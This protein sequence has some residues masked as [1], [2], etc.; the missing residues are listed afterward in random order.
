MMKNIAHFLLF[1]FSVNLFAASA[2]AKTDTFSTSDEFQNAQKGTEYISGSYPGAVLMPV[3]LMGAVGKAGVHHVPTKVDLL[4]FLSFAGGPN[5]DA[6]IKE[7]TLRR[8]AHGQE[9]VFD[10]NLNKIM[11]GP[12]K[13]IPIMEPNDIVYIPK[14]EEWVSSN[15]LKWITVLSLFTASVVSA[16]VINDHF[17]GHYP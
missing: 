12:A 4:T 1:V 16:L 10:L 14:K 17:K 11:H 13:D 9:D 5:G 7:I 6:D 2:S 15:S 8:R 3:S